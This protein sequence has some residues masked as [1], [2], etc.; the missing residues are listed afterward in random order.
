MV[1]LIEVVRSGSVNSK[2]KCV[3]GANEIAVTRFRSIGW[4][5]VPRYLLFFLCA[6]L[7]CCPNQVTTQESGTTEIWVLGTIQAL[8][9]GPE[10]ELLVLTDLGLTQPVRVLPGTSLSAFIRSDSTLVVSVSDL[11]PGMIIMVGGVRQMG[12]IAAQSILAFPRGSSPDEFAVDGFLSD[13][14]MTIS[15]SSPLVGTLNL[16]LMTGTTICSRVTRPST[17]FRSPL[18]STGF[19]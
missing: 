2:Y 18:F 15:F 4:K 10:P 7:I 11:E 13:E 5:T 19:R 9:A 6:I 16:N 8:T 17:A 14:T 3:K 1:E 12:S